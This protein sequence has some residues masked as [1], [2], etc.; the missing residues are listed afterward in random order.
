VVEVVDSSSADAHVVHARE[1]F[2]TA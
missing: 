2:L 1:R